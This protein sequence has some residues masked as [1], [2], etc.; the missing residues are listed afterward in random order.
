MKKG[1]KNGIIVTVISV[2]FFAFAACASGS[3]GSAPKAT[4][5]EITAAE[6]EV[7]QAEANLAVAEAE[8]RQAAEM[9]AA[10]RSPA[11]IA[12]FMEKKDA[13][14]TA[15]QVLNRAKTKLKRL[16]S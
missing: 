14:D 2:L 7:Q 16:Q 11:N 10:D 8:A 6:A 3:K 9:A 15:T 13:W 4:P 1:F 12:F 5:E